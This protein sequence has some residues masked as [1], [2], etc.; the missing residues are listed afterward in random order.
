V[1]DGAF[2]PGGEA[3][4]QA[5][6]THH[7]SHAER[8]TDRYVG[9]FPRGPPPVSGLRGPPLRKPPLRRDGCV[10]P[11]CGSAAIWSREALCVLCRVAGHA[12][13]GTPP[14]AG[15]AG[16]RVGV[17]QHAGCRRPAVQDC[18]SSVPRWTA[19]RPA[20]SRRKRVRGFSTKSSRPTRAQQ[21]RQRSP[22][23]PS[24]RQW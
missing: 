24:R 18:P 15:R 17:E 5:A 7:G 4:V 22:R 11:P 14:R 21:L 9:A 3:A 12:V 1:R 13:G 6:R 19:D 8:T 23:T 16:R 2:R 20:L 10:Y